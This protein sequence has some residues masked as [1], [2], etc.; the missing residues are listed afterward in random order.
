MVSQVILDEESTRNVFVYRKARRAVKRNEAIPQKGKCHSQIEK[1]SEKVA[2]K[3]NVVRTSPIFSSPDKV[4][5]R[6]NLIIQDTSSSENEE[7]IKQVD[8]SCSNK[9]VL[10]ANE[11]P[12][13]SDIYAVGRHTKP[14]NK[15]R[16]IF[17]LMENP[18]LND[19][20]INVDEYS[21]P[22]GKEK[23]QTKPK[24]ATAR[25]KS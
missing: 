21:P 17:K 13:I 18:R 24:K 20:V 15:L 14:K 12:P 8:F 4:K 19:L 3:K 22:K 16:W 6:R 1:S 5:K 11:S 9:S 2:E 25:P 23:V 10:E 7:S